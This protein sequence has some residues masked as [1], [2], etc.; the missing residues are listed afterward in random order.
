[1]PEPFQSMRREAMEKDLAGMRERRAF[2]VV[3]ESELTTSARPIDLRFVFNVKTTEGG[4]FD[5][6]KA[7]LVAKGF[8]QLCGIDYE[9]AWAPT[10]HM[11]TLRTLIA[12]A[13]VHEYDLWQADIT[14]AFLHGQL[15]P[16]WARMPGGTAIKIRV[17]NYGRK[18]GA[19]AW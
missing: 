6:C 18:Q 7:R 8:K 11:M 2:T 16:M 5:R 9:D 4:S 12:H 10:G 3:D 15:E 19:S 1:M 14:Q 17:A 13:G